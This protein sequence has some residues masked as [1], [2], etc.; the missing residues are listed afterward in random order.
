[1]AA[2]RGRDVAIGEPFSGPRGPGACLFQRLFTADAAARRGRRSH[3]AVRT[4]ARASRRALPTAQIPRNHARISRS[5]DPCIKALEI[6]YRFN[7]GS[8][9]EGGHAGL[10]KTIC[11]PDI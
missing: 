3:F 5:N 10:A 4:R 8:L 6:R 7:G 2:V 9:P 11:V 1:M